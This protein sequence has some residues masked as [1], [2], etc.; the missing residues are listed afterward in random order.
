M[1]ESNQSEEFRASGTELMIREELQ[2]EQENSDNSNQQLV[3]WHSP[4]SVGEA[5]HVHL[6]PSITENT[7]GRGGE[8]ESDI[9][10][11]VAG[12]VF[13]SVQSAVEFYKVYGKVKGFKV[14]IRSS[15]IG[16]DGTYQHVRLACTREGYPRSKKPRKGS[17]FASQKVGCKAK[18][19]LAQ[20]G[21]EDGKYIVNEVMLDHSHDLSPSN[22]KCFRC[23]RGISLGVRR[24]L[25]IN[26]NAGIT[27]CNNYT[28]IVQEYGGVENM[29]FTE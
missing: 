19:Y 29:R 6:Q 24:T 1:E 26:D 21:E 14:S 17:T 7:D 16:P 18:M 3:P 9:G 20:S 12:M 22:G 15:A 25:D 13:E 27:V 23:N 5:S 2:V 8:D 4:S 11:L 10:V 28:S